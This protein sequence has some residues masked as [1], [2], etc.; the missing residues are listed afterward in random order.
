M[1]TAYM[2][3]DVGKSK[4]CSPLIDGAKCSEFLVKR[5]GC[6]AERHL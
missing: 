4:F 2:L 6:C 3:G 5:L 1:N